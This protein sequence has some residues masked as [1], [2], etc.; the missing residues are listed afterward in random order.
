MPDLVRLWFGVSL[1]VDRRRYLF[2]GLALVAVKFAG[3]DV[4]VHLA[5]GQSWSPLDYLSPFSTRL[6]WGREV[7]QWLGPAMAAWALPF[8]WVG[9]SMT[10][11][12][13]LDARDTPWFVLLFFVPGANWALMAWLCLAPS[14]RE[15]KL[16]EEA[17]QA[18]PRLTAAMLGVAGGVCVGAASLALHVLLL[19]SYNSFVFLGT[20]FVM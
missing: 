8:L 14:R 7:P 20:P 17:R 9:A 1:R 4:L 3:D 19:R 12:R 2:S 11:R 6:L 13:L 18:A 16:D 15:Q 10:L 5:T